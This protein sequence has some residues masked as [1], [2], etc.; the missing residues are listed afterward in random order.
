MLLAVWVTGLALFLLM[1]G[2]AALLLRTTKAGRRSELELNDVTKVMAVCIGLCCGLLS[3][4][5]LID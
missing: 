2:S 1:W 4:L 5:L 3:L